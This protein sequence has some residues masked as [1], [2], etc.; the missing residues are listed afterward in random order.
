MKRVSK[1][2]VVLSALVGWLTMAVYVPSVSAIDLE[3]LGTFSPDN[4]GF[5][6]A[7]TV[8]YDSKNEQ[9]F[10]SN[11]RG[12]RVDIVAISEN[13]GSVTAPVSVGT[14]EPLPGAPSSVAVHG[15][16]VA[17]AVPAD[18]A[19][20]PGKVLFFNTDGIFINEVVVG[21]LPDMLIFTPDGR[22]VLVANEGEPNDDYTID[23]EG[24]VSIIDVSSA[25]VTT[26]DFQAFNSQ[27][28]QLRIDGV[29]IFGP[30]A[31]VAQDLEPEFITVSYDSTT[32]WVTLQE[33]NAI[34]T[35]DIPS[36]IVTSIMAL[37]F[38]D[39]SLDGNGLDASNEDG[40]INP[41][42]GRI[43]IAKWPVFGMYQPDG[44][45]SYH[46]GGQTYL[47]TAN[48]GDARDY[49]GFS[50]EERVK[51]L[52]LDPTVF[53]DAATLQ[54]SENLGRLKTTNALGDTD[55]D[56]DFDEIYA[57]GGRSFS[58]FTA[59]GALVFDS[60]DDF[61]QI[62]ALAVPGAF[63]SNGTEDSFDQRSDDKGA[64]PEG[65]VL[66]MILGRTY[67]F[68]GLERVG[69]IMVYDVTDPTAPVFQT[70]VKNAGDDISPEGLAF[71]SEADSPTRQPLLVVANEVSGTTTIY[72]IVPL[73]HFLC[74]EARGEKVKNVRVDLEDQFGFQ[75]QV[76]VKKPKLFCNPVAK[77]ADG[78]FTEISDVTAHLTG[79][80]IKDRD[81]DVKRR[82]LVGNQFGPEQ[83]L[84]VKEPKLLLV[85]S[86]KNGVR[87]ALNLDHF[88]CYEAKGRGDDDDD[89]DDD[90]K[91]KGKKVNV[92]VD[93]LDQFATEERVKVKRPKLFCNPVA[94]DKNGDG[95]VDPTAHLTCY[96]I[97]LQRH[98]RWRR[99]R[100]ARW[101]VTVQNQF[102]MGE[103]DLRVFGSR[104]QTLCVPST[105][106][107]VIVR[108]RDD[109]DD[110][111][112]D[113]KKT[114]KK[115]DDDD[116]EKD[117]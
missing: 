26:A 4:V 56:G 71:I 29:R 100:S 43:N 35:I 75:G 97:K 89:D 115:D 5:G 93:L 18:T 65:V 33:N 92:R 49:D 76:K 50:E 48:E 66:G 58:I 80:K 104:T 22:Q 111:D 79:Y 17:V 60:G 53:P 109:D 45:A 116:D 90:H 20:D 31:S 81:N 10:I 32:A 112:D 57:Y 103:Q 78:R 37:G 21:A 16:L 107:E 99:W 23:P 11:G 19:T 95:I 73:D 62:T 101:D 84:R 1:S 51:D 27:K 12:K 105:K 55:D 108:D 110:D 3:V 68:I 25:M 28:D 47:V 67:A 82:V 72:A 61:A 63:N 41:E 59:D 36:G 85:P 38:K 102:S 42:D 2:L 94:V 46:V 40:L 69:G 77:T 7:E 14:L 88:L 117:D 87:S 113:H 91:K 54:L 106:V 74:Y 15:D 86:E 6:A 24:S 8:A 114:R 83:R 70:Y 98:R 64:E 9:L 44:I 96:D 13:S 52:V 34:A 30:G 39:H